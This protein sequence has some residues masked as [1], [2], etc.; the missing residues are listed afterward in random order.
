MSKPT[1]A[2]LL[3][4][5]L[6]LLGF[7]EQ[8]PTTHYRVFRSSTTNTSNEW[9]YAYVGAAG[10]LRFN[11][12]GKVSQTVVAPRLRARALAAVQTEIEELTT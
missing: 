10:A 6:Q 3:A 9:T 7:T 2:Q 12:T 8:K 4:H 11:R 1:Q 5:G